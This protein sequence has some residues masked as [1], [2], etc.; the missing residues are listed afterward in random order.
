[1]PS[2]GSKTGERDQA[3]LVG[4]SD[5][6]ALLRGYADLSV[7]QGAQK[8]L[9]T[10]DAGIG[11]SSLTTS[12][13]RQLAGEGWG[14]H[15]GHC[16]EYADRPVPFGPIEHILRSLLV[17]NL[18]HLDATVD[19]FRA[20]LATLL[21][22][23]RSD[24]ELV[25]SS[26]ADVD[27]LFGVISSVLTE[28]SRRRPFIVLVEDIHWADPATRDLLTALGHNL[29]SAR[30]LLVAT[31]RTGALDRGHPLRTWMAERRRF[32]NVHGIDLEGLTHEEL[33]AQALHILDE[34]P[35]DDFLDNLLQRTGGNAYFAHEL[36]T[37]HRNGVD[38][39]P[40]S[41]TEF[42]TSRVEQRSDDERSVLRA[43]AV[44]GG[45]AGHRMLERMAEGVAVGPVLRSLFD[46]ALVVASGTEYKF[47]H[48]LLRDAILQ[49]VLPFE[50]QE[51]HRLAA[52][53]ISSDPKRGNTPSGL[54]SLAL[55]WHRA[56]VAEQTLPTAIQ[57]AEASARVSAFETAAELALQAIS[58]WEEVAEPEELSGLRR[59]TLFLRAADWL[60]LSNRGA[61]AV[62]LLSEAL[63]GWARELPGG[64]KALILAT[65]SATLFRQA[66]TAEAINFLGQAKQILGDEESP[67]AAEV[68]YIIAR[69]AITDGLAGPALVA[70]DL[71]VE[72]ATRYG[73][74]PI[75]IGAM[76][77]QALA[78]GALQTSAGGVAIA[79]EARS[80]ALAAGY[81]S[82]VAASYRV[83]MQIF[84]VQDGRTDESI[85]SQIEGLQFAAERCGPRITEE[86]RHDLALGYVEA[87]RFLEAK[88]LLDL[89]IKQPS[90]GLREMMVHQTA[91]LNAIWLRELDQAEVHL[92]RSASLAESYQS[93]QETGLHARLRAELARHSGALDQALDLIDRAL[94]LQEGNDNVSFTRES[95][96]EKV[97]IVKALAN[98][99]R[100]DAPSLLADLQQSIDR[101]DH[102][103]PANL[104]MVSLMRLELGSIEGPL[105]LERAVA[106]AEQL[107]SCGWRY[108]EA[109]VRLMV[110]EQ[111][112]ATSRRPAELETRFEA[113]LETLRGLATVEGM[114][115]IAARVDQIAAGAHIG[116]HVEDRPK[117]VEKVLPH[118]LTE[119]EMEVL[120]QLAL[121][122]T[123]KQIGEKLYVSSRTVST[124]VSNI[125]AKLGVANRAGAG[126]AYHRL[127]LDEPGVIDLRD[128]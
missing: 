91:A 19:L 125:L 83:E 33:G 57:A 109:L 77:V 63:D 112:Q 101:F 103:G 23:F 107:R 44:A 94:S 51:L 24:T 6:L 59:D 14:I 92:E 124:H 62:T 1:M 123:N 22:E 20:D 30:V 120:A 53:A 21:P 2:Q 40:E 64:R 37:A 31:A 78:T 119:R 81:P 99:G 35:S 79:R 87:G 50:A 47:R 52:E 75:L 122:L 82:Q 89:L 28:A 46:A 68:H 96:L 95:M 74:E 108:E 67:E 42:L 11:K 126:A 34:A 43:L 15:V 90:Q 73:P 49:D 48:A 69:Q 36:L 76:T 88:P 10:G 56:G 72:M 117:I 116:L 45:T 7:E 58:A 100:A 55:H 115:W 12:F 93:A 106:C 38:A 86:M 102:D 61:E 104:A 66:R 26:V 98:R 80:R 121:G 118:H 17:D 16:I 113:D 70:A 39:L 127:A 128:P 85:R 41:L 65:A 5:E 32:P 110:I 3:R 60:I 9:I 114:D 29:R 54:A 4:R 13:M 97:R 111:L 8:V 27:R 105:D 84:T 25:T 71:A 18:E